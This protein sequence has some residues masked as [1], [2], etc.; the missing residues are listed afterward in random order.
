MRKLSFYPLQENFN[1]IQNLICGIKV[2]D[3]F[4]H[5][6]ELRDSLIDNHCDAYLVKDD[7]NIVI[8]FFALDITTL[9]LDDDYKVDLMQGWL[10]AAKPE[11]QTEEELK[12]FLECKSFEVVDIAYLAVEERFQRLGYGKIIMSFIFELARKKKPNSIFMT[13]DA[14]HLPKINYS[15][16][17]FYERFGFQRMQPPT[18]DT[19]RMFCTIYPH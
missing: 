2:M 12:A 1:E 19:I 3:E 18:I 11:F 9:E 13:V 4:L 6:N 10:D 7:N 17:P 14:L 15:A 5:S 8:G 16:A